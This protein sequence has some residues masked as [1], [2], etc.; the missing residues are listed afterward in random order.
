MSRVIEQRWH[1]LAPLFD[2]AFELDANARARYLEAIDDPELRDALVRLLEQS[3]RPSP[4][5][6]GSEH[7]ARALIDTE[8]GVEGTILGS[9]KVREQIGAGG[10][11]TVFRAERADGAYQQQ[12]AIKLLRYGLHTGQERERFARERRILARL[13]HP[14]IAH[15]LDA[16]L[17]EAGVPWFALEFVDGMPI[18][19]WCDQHR[20]DV[21][22]RLRLFQRVCAAVDYAHRNLVVHRDLK[23]ANIFVRSDGALKLLDFGIA[24]VLDDENGEATRTEARRMTPAYAAPEQLAGGAITTATDVYALGVL[25]HELLTG[26][27]PHWRSDT[28]LVTPSSLMTGGDAVDAAKARNS[29][30]GSLRRRLSGDLDVI[31][32]KAL[33]SDPAQRYP[34]AA[35]LSADIERHL[36]G[37]PVRARRPSRCYRLRKFIVR[38]RLACATACAIALLIAVGVGATVWQ[39]RRANEAAQRAQLVQRYLVDLFGAGRT[40]AAGAQALERRVIDVLDDSA[41]RLHHDLKDVPQLRDEIYALLIEIFDSQNAGER[42]LR[43]AQER[44]AQAEAAFGAE[45]ARVAPALIQLALVHINHRQL[46]TVDDLLARAGRL[47]DAD[48]QNRSLTRALWWQARAML[49]GAKGQRNAESLGLLLQT[50]ALLREHHPDRDELL[51]SLFLAAQEAAFLEQVDQAHA[52]IAELKTRATQ[53]YGDHYQTIA[54]AG[55][56]EVRLLLKEGRAS[57]ALN[58]IRETREALIEFGGEQ[59]NDVLVTRYLEVNALLALKRASEAE[60]AWRLADAQQRAH[61]A[62]QPAYAAALAAQYEKIEAAL[63][64]ATVDGV[65]P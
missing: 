9:W 24:R 51:V 16:G 39:A 20:L 58:L 42:A 19:G 17:T 30:C 3:E 50:T 23:P 32:E 29:V 1:E 44:L 65:S 36:D 26:S 28:S 54:L 60:A 37:L 18:T 46:D 40:N 11:A 4:V 35:A 41:A 59:H 22:A 52:L 31:L 53:R 57:E 6:A 55:L 13:E 34:G 64:E 45:D 5:D 38:H 14:D 48:H 10:M 33:Q 15:L 8:A 27:R 21:T 25:L 61:F 62:D 7:L 56:V 47:L 12:V 63:A 49:M 43:L 2:A